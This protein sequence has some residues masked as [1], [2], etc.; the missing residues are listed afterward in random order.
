MQMMFLAP[1]ELYHLYCLRIKYNVHMFVLGLWQI[2]LHGLNE[3]IFVLSLRC[4]IFPFV[5]FFN[6]H[7]C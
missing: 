2:S 6:N 7:I 1:L 4:G 3:F 5:F